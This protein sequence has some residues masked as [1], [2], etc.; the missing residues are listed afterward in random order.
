VDQQH[1]YQVWMRDNTGRVNG[2]TFRADG[3]GR[4]IAVIQAPQPLSSYNDI[5]ITVEP[6]MGSDWPTTPRIVGGK[7]D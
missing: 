1:V 5:G 4:A 7:L 3:E 6:V 2:G